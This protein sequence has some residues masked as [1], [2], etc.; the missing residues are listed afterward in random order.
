MLYRRIETL[1]NVH[2]A[3]ASTE[4][5]SLDFKSGKTTKEPEWR[6]LAKD[7]AAFAN[8]VGGVLLVGAAE[9]ADNIATPYG[10]EPTEAQRLQSAYEEAARDKC[11][12]R[13]IITC[14]QIPLGNEKVV[15]AVNVE[16]YPDQ[17][18]G[19]MLPDWNKNGEPTTSHAWRFYVR[20]GKDNV[21]LS[22]DQLPMFMNAE[23]RRTV[24]RLESIPTTPSIVIFLVWRNP[25]NH[26][27]PTPRQ[28][29]VS[30]LEV[31]VVANV[32]ACDRS[33]EGAFRVRIPLD[34][35]EAVWESKPGQW[36]V[37]VTG[38]LGGPDLYVSNPSNASFRRP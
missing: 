7:I 26:T 22:P 11:A 24:I 1:A 13:P 5:R 21:P 35:V 20:I 27:E 23:I 37:R 31:D 32:F 25:T 36:M 15:L 12:P 3:C 30:G 17:L 2:A 33:S 29:K 18:V 8:H 34:D 16:P 28:E 14:K 38:H 4:G 6:E 19:A 9:S 10:L